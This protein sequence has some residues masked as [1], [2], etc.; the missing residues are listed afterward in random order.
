MSIAYAATMILYV[1]ANKLT[2]AANAIFLQS[3]A[4]L[5][6]LLLGPLLLSE[7]VERRQIPFMM[8]LAA[9]LC[10]FFVGV[11]PAS[12]TAP[13]PFR[14]NLLG[15][16]AGLSWGLAIMGLRWLGR[17]REDDAP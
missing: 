10:L 7:R 4:P 6:I 14:G 12:A 11:Q 5:Y 8:V 2:T 3:T 1:S 9:G 17:D 15:A 13:D 16:L